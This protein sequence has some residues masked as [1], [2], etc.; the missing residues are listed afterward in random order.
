MEKWLFQNDRFN[1][2]NTKH[3]ENNLFDSAT[4]KQR[5][6]LTREILDKEV[7]GEI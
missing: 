1:W 6:F 4:I 7:N 5:E 2:K 3:Y